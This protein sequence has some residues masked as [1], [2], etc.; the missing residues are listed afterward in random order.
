MSLIS[1]KEEWIVVYFFL[2]SVITTNDISFKGFCMERSEYMNIWR[3][4]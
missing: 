3:E 4:P 2:S 1:S